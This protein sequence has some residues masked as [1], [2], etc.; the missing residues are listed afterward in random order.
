MPG[1][2]S[3][4]AVTTSSSRHGD[5]Q[6]NVPSVTTP[7]ARATVQR[8]DARRG[9]VERA[10]A[11]GTACSANA[12]PA[13]VGVTPRPARTNRSAPSA[14]SSWR[15]WSATA[16]CETCSASA[17]AVNEPSSA[18]AQKHRSCCRDRSSALGSAKQATLAWGSAVPMMPVMRN[19]AHRR[20]RRRSASSGAATSCARSGRPRRSRPGQITLLRVV[21]GFVPVRALR[22]RAAAPCPA[23]HVR[24]LHHFLV[25]SVLATSVYYFAFASGARRCCRRAS[26]AGSPARS[27]CSRCVGAAVF[28]RSERITPVRVV[29]VLVGFGGVL[30]IARPWEAE[31]RR[32]HDRRALHPRRARRASAS[33]SSTPS[34]SSSASTSRRPR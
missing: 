21:F 8:A 6:L 18:A 28:L 23:R 1:W 30:L 32:R 5:G 7:V 9:V 22:A 12:W 26:P 16:G 13:S 27:R 34:G 20:L 25:M 31:R 4:N 17:A 33:R 10:R 29:G 14:R 11:C 3:R 19:P 24:H 2:R 15:T